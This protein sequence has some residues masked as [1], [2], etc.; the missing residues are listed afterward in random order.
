LTQ[1]SPLAVKIGRMESNLTLWIGIAVV[2]LII[3]IVLLILW[4]KKRG[5]DKK[6]SFDKPEEEPKELTQQQKSGNYQAQSGLNF[7]PA[8][9][10]E[11]VPVRNDKDPTTEDTKP[12]QAAALPP[13]APPPPVP[14][15]VPPTPN[16][17]PASG[18]SAT[19]EPDWDKPVSDKAA[20]VEEENPEADS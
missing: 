3:V 20:L 2:V 10:V 5:E 14:S 18:E 9:C 6:V 17:E 13:E 12:Q 15:V 11:P 8:K 7:A 1:W 19:Q 4:G 16:E